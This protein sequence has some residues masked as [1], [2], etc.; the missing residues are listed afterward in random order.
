MLY[1]PKKQKHPK[2]W[3][4]RAAAVS[5]VLSASVVGSSFGVSADTVSDLKQQLAT[6]QQQSQT[7]QQE[8]NDQ[9]SKLKTE[10]DKKAAIDAQVANTQKQISI[11]QAQIDAT[12]AQIAVKQKDI[13]NT[14]KSVD[15]NYDLLKQRM[16]T[17]YMAGNESY[18][19]VLL[20]SDSLPDFLNNAEVIRTVSKHDSDIVD[21]LKADEE[22]LKADKATLDASMKDLSDKQ[23]TIAAQKVVLAAQQSAQA[24]TVAQAKQAADSTQQQVSAVNAKAKQ[25]Q[26]DIAAEA[27]REQ[28]AQAAAQRAAAARI[29]ALAATGATGS[30]YAPVGQTGSGTV[31]A[32]INLAN[33]LAVLKK[34]YVWGAAGPD[35][36]DC[37][38]FTQYVF[39]KTTSFSG[40][41]ELPHSSQAQYEYGTPVSKDNLQAGD[42][43]FFG[44]G[45]A[46][47]DHVGIY[48]GGGQFIDAPNSNSYVR[49]DTLAYWG[50]YV[51]AKRL[52]G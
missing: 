26:N 48:V 14:Q 39:K 13:D 2:A 37:S 52:L 47:I 46:G 32:V 3:G 38:G 9:N 4:L 22:R 30:E 5:I 10:Q 49:Y 6:L 15:E 41:N 18:L 25:T 36:F 11:L 35:S 31:D 23:S 44:S 50:N 16:R 43:V 19:S 12:N 40:A 24:D 33:Q 34:P 28:E 29:A 17:L 20:S 21:G 27:K 8:L 7:L 42:L 1:D 45:P 51:G